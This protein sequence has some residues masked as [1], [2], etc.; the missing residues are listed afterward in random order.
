MNLI[1]SMPEGVQQSLMADAAFAKDYCTHNSLLLNFYDCSCFSLE[2]VNE[3]IKKGPDVSLI[4][5]IQH[6]E[7]KECVDTGLVYG[8]GQ[9]RCNDAL[10]QMNVTTGQL[11]DICECSGKMLARNYV[12]HPMPSIRFINNLFTDVLTA[13]RQHNGF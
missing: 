1:A 7:Y 9:N 10:T 4:E 13:C 12:N 11:K 3:R 8:Y 5:L 2:I 6:G